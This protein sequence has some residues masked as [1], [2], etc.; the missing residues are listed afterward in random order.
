M[1][2]GEFDLTNLRLTTLVPH[3]GRTSTGVT[4]IDKPASGLR[5]LIPRKAQ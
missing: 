3:P 4:G 2:D 5:G 1:T